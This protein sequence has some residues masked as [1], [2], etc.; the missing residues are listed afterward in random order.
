VI[1]IADE[2]AAEHSPVSPARSDLG[3]NTSLSRRVLT[4]IDRE[5]RRRVIRRLCV[6]AGGCRSGYLGRSCATGV[7]TVAVSGVAPRWRKW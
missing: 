2:A 6:A 4:K 3:Q 1:T 7:L 5:G